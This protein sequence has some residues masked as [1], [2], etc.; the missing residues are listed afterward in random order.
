MDVLP[1]AYLPGDSCRVLVRAI[2]Q[3]DL[4]CLGTVGSSGEGAGAAPLGMS[5]MPPATA[6]AEAAPAA[7]PAQREQ[8]PTPAPTLAPAIVGRDDEPT[9]AQLAAWHPVLDPAAG[10]W[11][12]HPPDLHLIAIGTGGA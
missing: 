10:D 7:D 5:G 4:G 1:L 3:L 9:P 11:I 8:R 6:A 2:G 12:I